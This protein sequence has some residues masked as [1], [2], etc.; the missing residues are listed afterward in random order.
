MNL[1]YWGNGMVEVEKD[2]RMYICN[3]IYIYIYTVPLYT[4]ISILFPFVGEISWNHGV[5]TV[6]A[7][8]PWGR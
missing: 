8:N 6:H 1:G 7:E 2:I 5:H 3:T 4:T